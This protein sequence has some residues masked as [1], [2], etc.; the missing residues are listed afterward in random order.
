MM[1]HAQAQ[2]ASQNLRVNDGS[3]P[4]AH[5]PPSLPPCLAGI[6]APQRMSPWEPFACRA[7]AYCTR[8]A[9]A[10]VH[11]QA[12]SRQ[13]K[14]AS[15]QASEKRL[16]SYQKSRVADRRPLQAQGPASQ[17]AKVAGLTDSSPMAAGVSQPGFVFANNSASPQA[18]LTHCATTHAPDI[19]RHSR[20]TG[21]HS[22]AMSWR[23]TKRDATQ[24]GAYRLKTSRRRCLTRALYDTRSRFAIRCDFSVFRLKQMGCVHEVGQA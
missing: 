7:S 8:H 21:R 4:W 17:P 1:C 18:H 14:L 5:L 2:S 16:V 13:T 15:V 3:T 20:P 9:L 6:N 24:G 10:S 11:V 12:G 19:F 23:P 22:A